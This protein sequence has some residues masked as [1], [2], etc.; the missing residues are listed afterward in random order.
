MSKSYDIAVLGASPAG[1]VA[2]ITL[3]DEGRRV[4]L[5]DAPCSRAESPRSDWIPSDA[6]AGFPHLKQLTSAVMDAPFKA[7]QFHSEDLS[8][9]SAYR[10]RSVLGYR[11]GAGTLAIALGK[12]AERCGVRRIGEKAPPRVGL[13]E[14]GVVLAGRQTVRASLLLI[15]QGLPLEAAANLALPLRPAPTPGMSV[16]ALDVP[17]PGGRAPRNIGG[18]L[19]V[20]AFKNRARLGM[21][22]SAGKVVH[23]RV[24]ALSNNEAAAGGGEELGRLTAR[25]LHG[26]WLPEKT[27]L[28]AAAMSV[29]RPPGGAAL[30]QEVLLAKRTLLI[31]TAGGFASALSG[32]TID[33]S[34]RSA[35]IAVE[36]VRRALAK[37]GSVQEAL[38]EFK[39][40][41]RD[42]DRGSHRDLSRLETSTKR[43]G[44]Q[45]RYTGFGD[46]TSRLGTPSLA[47]RIRPPGASLQML[48]PMVL[49]NRAIAA[50]FARALLYGESL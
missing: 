15:A 37:P 44:P 17:V 42:G 5:V 7:V 19:H 47:D 29:W 34:V 43:E 2:A 22:F 30:E 14:S 31:G 27:D 16:C 21:F 13:E 32:Q 9:H 3:A 46:P 48:L 45:S 40:R 20:V 35:A 1:Y 38:G 8:S 23:V 12:I 25:L 49:S 39:T 10:G 6:F 4:V 26:G 18:D 24:V 50:K 41:W 33:P 11:L 28:R 36:V